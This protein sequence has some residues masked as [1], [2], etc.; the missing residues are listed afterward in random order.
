MLDKRVAVNVLVTVLLGLSLAGAVQ[1]APPPLP[2]S[3]YGTVEVDGA[4]VPGGTIISAW[5]DGVQYAQGTTSFYAGDS[6]YGIDVPGDHPDT[7]E[8]DGGVD[9]DT[10]TFRIGDLGADQTGT[11]NG[12]SNVQLNL[13]AGTPVERGS[14]TVV[15]ETDPDGGRGFDFGGDLGTFGLGDGDSEEFGNLMPGD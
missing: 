4:N 8:K 6:V 13:T 15:K 3:F 14:I 2:S 7:P 5:I 1:A 10:I 9:G 11:W 12:G